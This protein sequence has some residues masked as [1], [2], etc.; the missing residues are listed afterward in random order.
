MAKRP[1]EADL[2]KHLGGQ[3][4]ED[5]AERGDDNSP[6]EAGPIPTDLKSDPQLQQAINLLNG[7]APVTAQAAP[8]APAAPKA[9]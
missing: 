5:Q 9:N 6:R 1:S 2:P 7:I 4:D 8:A 3:R